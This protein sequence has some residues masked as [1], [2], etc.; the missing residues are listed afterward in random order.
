[1]VAAEAEPVGDGTGSGEGRGLGE[2]RVAGDKKGALE[3][4]AWIVFEDESGFSLTP[5]IRATWAPRGRTPVLRYRFHWQRVSAAGFLCFRPDG[6]RA[7][8][9][10]DTHMGSYNSEVLI[11]ALR[12]L[13]RRLRQ[14]MVLL[15]DGLTCHWGGAMKKFVEKNAHWLRTERLPAYAPD[16]NPCEGLWAYLKGGE[17]ANRAESSIGVIAELAQIGAQR[18]AASQQLVFSFLAQTGLSLAL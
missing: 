12:A 16:L 15:W 9:Y 3:A 10:L 14:P 17:L 1:M 13:R 2:E 8:L 5:P 18:A 4:G 11:V 6:S 7:R